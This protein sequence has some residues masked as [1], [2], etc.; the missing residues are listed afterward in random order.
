MKKKRALVFFLYSILNI[1]RFDFLKENGYFINGTLQN[2][3]KLTLLNKKKEEDRK[4][5]NR[6]KITIIKL[7]IL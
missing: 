3:C 6:V 7:K 1:I 5:V 2:I 4:A